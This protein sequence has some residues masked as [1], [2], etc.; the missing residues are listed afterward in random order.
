MTAAANAELERDA[1]EQQAFEKTPTARSDAR[2]VRAAKAVP[3]WH[4]T[5]PANVIV[6]AWR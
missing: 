5:I 3:T 4:A 2:S 1:P 6:V